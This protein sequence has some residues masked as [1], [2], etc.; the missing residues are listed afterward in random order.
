VV[1]GQLSVVGA[2]GNDREKR[3]AE[4]KLSFRMQMKILYVLVIG[5]LVTNYGFPAKH[6]KSALAEVGKDCQFVPLH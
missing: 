6:E 5:A 3:V 2:C 1:S 4:E